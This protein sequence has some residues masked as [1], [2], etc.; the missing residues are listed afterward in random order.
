MR[1]VFFLA[2]IVATCSGAALSA[3]AGV[4]L[5]IPSQIVPVPFSTTNYEFDLTFSL[6]APTV[7]QSL[8]GYDLYL[9]IAGGSGLTI[10]GVATGSNVPAD[11]VFDSNPAYSVQTDANGDTLYSFGSFPLSGTGTITNG[12]ALLGVDAQLRPGATGTYDISALVSASGEPTTQFYSGIDSTGTP[13]PITGMTFETGAISVA[14]PGDANLDGRVDVNDLTIL[15]ANF[16][17][18]GATWS[19]GEFTGDGTVDVNDLTILLTN[20][21]ASLGTPA[22]TPAPE[23]AAGTLLAAGLLGVLAGAWRRRFVFFRRR[24][25]FFPAHATVGPVPNGTRLRRKLFGRFRFRSWFR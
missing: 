22:M 20:F 1:R 21:G 19:E 13:I 4:M 11:A 16:G 12:S 24:A 6:T 8:Q 14:L 17:Q 10:T 23:P 15:L 7:S 9:T 3:S 5:N 18:T 2:L 25:P